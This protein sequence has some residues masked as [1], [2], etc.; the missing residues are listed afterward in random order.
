[1]TE[2]YTQ[3][4]PFVLGPPVL[5]TV[6]MFLYVIPNWFKSLEDHDEPG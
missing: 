5:L 4:L 1:M 3:I 6:F 2:W